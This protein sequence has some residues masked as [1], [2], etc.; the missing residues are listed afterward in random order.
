MG[1]EELT[2]SITT[3]FEDTRHVSL[4]SFLPPTLHFRVRRQFAHRKMRRIA[5]MR[6][7]AHRATLLGTYTHTLRL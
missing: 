4:R 5:A 2:N 6:E 3:N 1:M 7:P